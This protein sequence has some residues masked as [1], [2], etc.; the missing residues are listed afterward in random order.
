MEK[1]SCPPY[2]K[3][4]MENVNKAYKDKKKFHNRASYVKCP[5]CGFVRNTTPAK[6]KNPNWDKL[7][8]KCVCLKTFKE[9]FPLGFK[10]EEWTIKDH[11]ISKTGDCTKINV[12]CSCGFET[13]I[14]SWTLETNKTK[15]CVKCA[16]KKKF[17]GYGEISDTYFTRLKRAAIQRKHVFDITIKYIWELFL[18]QNRRC[19]ISGQLLK[20]TNSNHFKTQ[21]ASLDRIDSSK[22]YIVGNIQW[23]HKRINIMKMDLPEEE[24]LHFIKEIYEFN[25]LNKN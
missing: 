25:H 1:P 13:T 5:E 4:F 17:K 14:Q 24:F 15:S 12:Q 19:A 9:K 3:I 7:C 8:H 11:N 10:F 23:V 22:G 18:K 2:I 6:H 20:L 16:Y 21:T